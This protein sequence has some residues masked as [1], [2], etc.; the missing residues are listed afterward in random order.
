M[1]HNRIVFSTVIRYEDPIMRDHRVHGV[2]LLPGV[3]FLDLLVRILVRKGFQA[4]QVCFRKLLFK[5]AIAT[6]ESF[7][8]RIRFTFT[9]QG[10][11]WKITTESRKER[12][13]QVLDPEWEENMEGELHLE[14]GYAPQRQDLSAFRERGRKADLDEAYAI[15]RDGNIVH[16]PFMKGLGTAHILDNGLLAD[17]YLSAEADKYSKH[18]YFHPAFLD[19]STLLPFLFAL[20][21]ARESGD[22]APYIPI[23]VDQF[24]FKSNFGSRVSVMLHLRKGALG[25]DI[26]T[27][28]LAFCDSDG[29]TLA[30]MTGLTAKR[31]RFS[32]LIEALEDDQQAGAPASSSAPAV[33]RAAAVSAEGELGDVIRGDLRAMVG[34]M[35]EVP[36][37]D[38]SMDEG[39]YD[40]GLD[41]TALL[42]LVQQLEAKLAEKLYP[43]LLFEYTN[44][45]DLAGYLE[46]TFGERYREAVGRGDVDTLESSGEQGV[47][48]LTMQ[49]FAAPLQA[50]SL[51]QGAILVMAP[52]QETFKS[53]AAALPKA[54]TVYAVLPGREF[55]QAGQQFTLN[56]AAL[57]DGEALLQALQQQGAKLRY[58]VHAWNWLQAC[59]DLEQLDAE[60]RNS[61]Y[62]LL[63][64]LRAF[65]NQHAGKPLRV[66]SLY[67]GD[68]PGQAPV[69]AAL[70]GFAGTVQ[71]ESPKINLNAV[72]LHGPDWQRVVEE[73]SD[74]RAGVRDVV[75][76]PAGR[77]IRV[78]QT[79]SAPAQAAVA[80]RQQGC[81]VITGG[82]GGLGRL[83][84]EW[85]VDQYAAR[86]VLC[87]RS[88][89]SQKT[90]ELVAELEKRGGKA[91]YVAVDIG[92]LAETK[93]LFQLAQER[94]GTVHGILHSAGVIRDAFLSN[95]TMADAEAVL[96][97]KVA[98]TLNL[99][100]AS[101]NVELDFFLTCSSVAG[102]L[103]N[104]GQSD[105]AY[106][107]AFMD[108]FALWREAQQVGGRCHGNTVSVNWPIWA[109]GGMQLD[110]QAVKA[111]AAGSGMVPLSKQEGLAFVAQVIGFPAG[112]YAIL[113]GDPARMQQTFV[114]PAPVAPQPSI[115]QQFAASVQ[116]LPPQVKATKAS[117]APVAMADDEIAVIGLAGRYPKAEDVDAFW[118]NLLNGRDC[119]SEVPENRWDHGPFFDPQKG[120]FGKTNGKWGGFLD[121]PEGFDPLFFNLNPREMQFADPQERLFLMAA[122]QAMED[123]GYTRETLKRMKTGVYCGVMWSD[124]YLIGMPEAL[125]G[126]GPSG[127]A[128][129][130]AIP[131]RVSFVLD[132]NGPSVAIDTMCSSVLTSLNF[133]CRSI[134]TGETDAAF[135]GGV[136]LSLHPN[137]YLQLALPGFLSSDGRC[138]AFGEGGDGY[139]PSEGVGVMLVKRLSQA[140]ADGDQIYGVIKSLAVNH[141]GKAGGFTVPS[142]VA[143]GNLIREALEQK[144][145][146]PASISY[147]ETHGT[148]TDLGDPIEI[149]G[150][151]RAFKS[152]DLSPGQIAIGSVKSNIGHLESAAAVAGLT[153]VLLQLKHGKLVPSLHSDVLNPQIRFDQVPFKVQHEAQDWNPTYDA[154]GQ[155]LPR[156]AALSSFGAG[157]TNGHVIIEEYVDAETAADD[158]APQ[159]LVLSAR[160][161]ERLRVYAGKL[162][163]HLER[164][165]AATGGLDGTELLQDVLQHAAQLLGMEADDLDAATALAEQGFDTVL[166]AQLAQQLAAS[167]GPLATVTAE[168]LTMQAP[169]SL[170]AGIVA[171]QSADVAVAAS[172]R[173]VAHTLQV[174]RES[175]EARL[176]FSATSLGQAAV[177]FSAFAAGDT[178]AG[179]LFHEQEETIKGAA[180]REL[181]QAVQKALA[182]GDRQ[183]LMALWV[184]GAAVDWA[185][186]AEARARRV[187]LPTY[188]FLLNPVWIPTL[189]AG[190]ALGKSVV[191]AGSAGGAAKLHPFLDR[192]CSTFYDL[193]FATSLDADAS[194]MREHVVQGQR[195]FPGV[196]YLEMA[197]AAGELAA[198]A[199]VRMLRDVFWMR[200]LVVEQGQR[201]VKIGLAPDQ[202]GAAFEVYEELDGKRH[203]FSKGQVLWD[204]DVA[205]AGRVDLAAIQAR[206]DLRTDGK[207]CYEHFAAMGFDY[208][209]SYQVTQQ[210]W[211]GDGE[212]LVE[213]AL[214]EPDD[215]SDFVLPPGLT[216]GALR[217]CVAIGFDDG[218][219]EGEAEP[220]LLIPFS[221]GEI[222]IHGRLPERVFAHAV[223]VSEKQQKDT[224]QY[225]VT[226]SDGD[227]NVLAVFKQFNARAY[228][229][230]QEATPKRQPLLA[231]EPEWP[232]IVKIVRVA[233]AVEMVM[234][235][236]RLLL[237]GDVPEDALAAL[238]EALGEGTDVCHLALAGAGVEAKH[239]VDGDELPNWFEEQIAASS[240]PDAILLW[241]NPAAMDFS[242]NQIDAVTADAEA[243]FTQLAKLVRALVM[244]ARDKPMRVVVA[245]QGEVEGGAPVC[246]AVISLASSLRPLHP[247]L[248]L[249][250]LALEP[251]ARLDQAKVIADELCDPS[252]KHGFALAYRDGQ[253][254]KRGLREVAPEPSL[255]AAFPE[256]GVCLIS[257]G[258]GGL[259]RVFASHLAE[260]YQAKLV[261]TGRSPEDPEKRAF[262]ESLCNAIYVQADVTTHAGAQLARDAAVE[263]FGTLDGV[264]HGAGALQPVTLMDATEADWQRVLQPKL[265]GTVCLDWV[266]RNDDLKVFMPLGSI[267]A[268]IGD[269]GLGSY[270]FGNCFVD[271]FCAMR[272]RLQDAGLRQGRAI[273][274]AW[275]LWA[276]G[277]ME[278]DDREA[279][280]YSYSGMVPMDSDLALAFFDQALS[281][282]QAHWVVAQ[283]QPRKVRQAFGLEVA[284]TDQDREASPEARQTVV[285]ADL[286]DLVVAI[287]DYLKGVMAKVMDIEIG[288]IK[289]KTSFDRYGID[290]IV[291]MEMN[292][293]MEEAF[294]G[295][296][297]TLFFEHE[298]LH[299]IAVFLAEEHGDL[300]AEK[301]EVSAPSST[302]VVEATQ[303]QHVVAEAEDMAKTRN[304]LSRDTQTQ[305]NLRA[306]GV[307]VMPR[308]QKIAIIGVSG[309]YP[310]ARNLDAFWELLRKGESAITEVPESRWRSELFYDAEAMAPGKTAL[311]YGGFIDGVA[312]FD[313]LHFNMSP[314]EAAYQDPQERLFLEAVWHA[315][316]NA[317][318]SRKLLTDLQKQAG[319][320]GVYVASQYR[321][322]PMLAGDESM[323]PRYS[324]NSASSLA[325]RVSYFFNLSG[326]SIAL[327]TA[328]SGSLTAVHLACE[329]LM[330][331]SSSMAIA[332]GVNLTLHP[333]KYIGLGELGLVGTTSESRSFGEGDGMI[334]GEGVGAL[335]LKPLEA[336]IAD[337]D[338]I[339]GVICASGVNHGGKTAGFAMPNPKMQAKL[340]NETLDRAG[341]DPSSI[342]YI[343]AA[344][345]G[346]PVSDP[347]EH[348][349]LSRA[350]AALN[351]AGRKVAVGS[352]KSNIGHLEAASG[353]SQVTKVL[354]QMQHQT[355]VPSINAAT[356]PPQI[357]WEKGPLQLQQETTA[358][359]APDGQPLRAAVSSFGAGGSNAHVILEAYQAEKPA[360]VDAELLVVFSARNQQR[361][362]A[363]LQGMVSFFE[364]QPDQRLCDVAFS[365]YVGREWQEERVA[366]VAKDVRD[367][368]E[369]IARF[370][371]GDRVLAG[372]YTSQEKGIGAF[373]ESLLEGSAGR[374]FME[375]LLKERDY[376]K[377]AQ[378][379]V[380][381][382]DLPSE[383]LFPASLQPRRVSLPLYPFERRHC[384]LGNTK[385]FAK[386]EARDFVYEAPE[387]EASA[388]LPVAAREGGITKQS[389]IEE[390]RSIVG[391]FLGL[392]PHELAPD[393]DLAD[394]GF[395]SFLGMKLVNGLNDHFDIK[396]STEVLY[397]YPTLQ[398]LAAYLVEVEQLGQ[399]EVVEEKTEKLPIIREYPLA[400]NQKALWFIHQ[401]E[402]T[403]NMPSAFYLSEDAEVPLLREALAFLFDRHDVLRATTFAKDGELINHINHF[404]DLPF[405]LEDCSHM[406]A[407]AF[408]EHVSAIG[409]KVFD[410]ESEPLIRAHVLVRS[411]QERVLLVVIHHI[412]FD[413]ASVALLMGE[414]AQAYDDLKA[415]KQ[416]KLPAL[417]A[418]YADYV[419]WQQEMLAGEEGEAHWAYWKKTL[420]GELPMLELP[421]DYPRK[422]YPTYAG[423]VVVAELDDAI[424]AGLKSLAKEERASL[425]VVM[426]A[427]FHTLLVRH[428]RQRDIII[429][430][431]LSGRS[432]SRFENVLG[433]FVNVVPLRAQVD[434]NPSFR[435]FLRQMKRVVIESFDHGDY[436]MPYLVKKLDIKQDTSRDPVAQVGFVLH[437]F[438]QR[439]GGDSEDRGILAGD[440]GGESY[441]SASQDLGE[442]SMEVVTMGGK[443]VVCIKFNT[444]LYARPRI[445]GMIQNYLTLL[446]SILAQP[447]QRV[448]QLPM[449]T[450]HEEQQIVREWNVYPDAYSGDD[451]IHGMVMA[452][453]AK[454]GSRQAVYCAD[455]KGNEATLNYDELERKSNQLAHALIEKGVQPETLVAVCMDRTPELL[456]VL[457]AILK[458]G[459][460]YVPL[461]PAYPQDRLEFIIKDT[462]APVLI[463]QKHL[464]EQFPQGTAE[465]VFV[466]DWNTLLAGKPETAPAVRVTPD[467]LAYVIFTSGSTGKPKGVLITHRNVV[468]L[469]EAT[470]EW[471]HFDEK[472][473]W[474]LFHS[475]AFDFSVWEIWGALCYG[476]KLVV[477]PH[478][479]ARS[480]EAVHR[481]VAEQKVTIF[482][483]TPS[484]FQQFIQVDL[485]Q[486]ARMQLA[487]REIVF[488]GEALDF[489]G[490]QHWFA[491][492]GYDQPR[493]VNMYGI[494]ETTVHVTYYP[495]TQKRVAEAGGSVI[496]VPIP[497]L[498]CYLL[499]ESFN[500]V[501]AGVPAEIH[502]GGAGLARG[503][504]NRPDL[505]A[506][507]FIPNAFSGVAGSR[508]YRSGD[509]ARF[510]PNGE[511]EYL[512]RID[513]QVKIRGFRIELGEIESVMTSYPG[514]NAAV[515]LVRED[516][517]GDKRLVGYLLAPELAEPAED[518]EG[519]VGPT[520][521]LKAFMATRLP[522]YMIPS[523][524][525]WLPEFPL[526][527][528][529]KTDR[530]KLPKPDVSRS[531]LAEDYVAPRNETEAALV[532]MW[533]QILAVER[534][535]IYDNFFELGGHSLL[536]TQVISAIRQHF[537]LDISPRVMFER[538]TIAAL[539]SALET[540]S[541]DVK[542]SLEPIEAAGRNRPLPLSF[543]Q[544]RLWFF[545]QMEPGNAS[546][547]LASAFRFKGNFKGDVFERALNRLI[548]RHESLRTT[549]L[550]T[551]EDP[552]QVI[553]EQLPI[554][555]SRTSLSHYPEADRHVALQQM[556]SEEAWQPFDLQNGPLV[557]VSLFEMD[558]DDQVLL[559][560]F[561]H[562]ISDGWS[563]GITIAELIAFYDAEEQQQ[564]VTL[565]EMPIQYADFAV[566]QREWWAERELQKQIDY[567]KRNLAGANF[568][569]DLP[570]DF[571]R[572]RT[573]SMEGELAR[574]HFD[575]ELSVQ[576]KEFCLAQGVT[577][578]MTLLSV[579]NVLLSRY[580]GQRD[581]LIG[582]AIAN[583]N[584]AELENLIGFFVNT[585]VLRTDLAGNPTCLDLLEQ[586][587]ENTLNAYAHQDVSFEKLVEELKPER[588]PSRSPIYQVAFAMQNTP[589]MDMGET[590]LEVEEVLFDRRIARWDLLFDVREIDGAFVGLVEYDAALFRDATIQRML[591]HYQTLLQAFISQPRKR[592]SNLKM[593]SDAERRVL[594]R[595]WND[596][597]RE[598]PVHLGVP[599]LFEAQV[600]RT[601][602]RT[603]LE[604]GKSKVSYEALNARANVVARTLQTRGAG[605][606]KRV[607]VFMDRSPDMIVAMLAIMKAGSA[608]VP[609]DPEYPADRL[610]YMMADA[611]LTAI[612]SKQKLAK[613]MPETDVPVVLIDGKN[614]SAQHDDT[615]LKTPLN[616][617]DV[618]Y[619]M[620]TSGSTGRPKGSEIPHRGIIRLVI[621]TNYID[622]KV[623]GRIAQVAS[624][625]FDAATFEIWGPLLNGGQVIGVP[626]DVTLETEPLAAYL[627]EHKV[628]GM[629]MTAGLFNQH[630]RNKPD[631][632]A[633]VKTLSVGGEA[634]DPVWIRTALQQG[635][636]GRILNGYGPTE[637]TTFASW[638]HVAEVGEQQTN[639]PIGYPIANTTLYVL[640]KYLQLQPQGV[641]GE[642]CIGG[643]GLGLSYFNRPDL[644]ADKFIPDPFSGKAGARLYRTGDLTRTLEDGAITYLGRIDTQVKMRGYRIELGEIEA[645]LR[646]HHS[647]KDV[648]VVAR[649]DA[650]GTL[651]LVGYIQ[652]EQGSGTQDSLATDLR[653]FL[654]SSLPD[655]M[656]PTYFVIMDAFPLTPN[657]KID[658]RALPDPQVEKKQ[659][660][661]SFKAPRTAAEKAL[662]EIWQELLQVER[663]G[664]EDN[665]F[666]LG[667]HS[668]LATRLTTQIRKR[669]R[670]DIPIRTFFEKATLE[671][672]ADE[673]VNRLM[674]NMTLPP[675]EQ[676][677]AEGP[678]PIPEI[679]RSSAIPLSFSQQ[680]LW[681]IDQL[682]P[683]NPAYNITGGVRIKGDIEANA[684]EKALNLLVQRHETLRTTFVAPDGE[685]YQV[686][687]ETL[688]IP[689]ERLDI[690]DVD[691][692]DR[693]KAL[694]RIATDE[695][696]TPFNLAIGPLLR[697]K[698]VHVGENDFAL[699]INMHHIVSDGWSLGVLI[700]ELWQIMG[701]LLMDQP[702][703][704]PP[705]PCQFADFVVWHRDVMDDGEMARQHEYWVNKL[706]GANDVLDIPTDY[707]RPNTPTFMGRGLSFEISPELTRK[708]FE[709]GRAEDATLFMVMMTGFSMLMARYSGQ[710]DLLIGTPSANRNRYETELMIGLFVNTLAIRSNYEARPTVREALHEMRLTALD[711]FAHNE[712]PFDKLVEEFVTDRDLSRNPLVQV[713]LSY[714]NMPMPVMSGEDLVVEDLDF[715][716][717]ITRNEMI[718]HLTE[719]EQ[720][721]LTGNLIYSLDL[722]S[723]ASMK[724]LIQ[725][726]VH[727]LEAMVANPDHDAL[728]LQFMGEDEVQ[729]VVYE[730]NHTKASY[731]KG[732]TVLD[733]Y[734]A[735][736]AKRADQLA[737]ADER[738]RM[739]YSHLNAKANQLAHK[740]RE[741]GVG[742]DVLV[743]I[744]ME[745]RL[746]VIVALLAI[747][748]AGGAYVPMDSKHPKDRL[749]MIAEDSGMPVLL[750]HR[751]LE[752]NLPDDV[753]PVLYLDDAA[754]QNAK[755]L[756]QEL[757]S[758]PTTK[759]DVPGFCNRHLA[760]AIYTSGSTGLP[761][762]VMIEHAQLLNYTLGAMRRLQIPEG[763]SF[764]LVSTFAADLGNTSIYGSL[765]LGGSLHVL[766]TETATLG[767]NLGAY[768]KQNEIEVIKIVPS[769]LRALLNSES[770]QDILPK[771]YLV[772]GGEACTAELVREVQA[773]E[774]S[775]RLFN[776]YGPSEATVG[777]TAFAID[778]APGEGESVLPLGRPFG[779]IQLYI[780]D[781]K[782]RPVPV[783]FPGELCIAGD[784]VARG[785]M[786]R[787]HLTAERFVPNPFSDA[788]GSRMYRTGDLVRYL[789]DGNVMF[790]GRIDHQVKIRGYR[791]ELG[792]IEAEISAMDA[793]DGCVVMAK[794]HQGENRIVAWLGAGETAEDVK[795]KQELL[796]QVRE[797]LAERLPEYMMPSAFMVLAAIPLTPNGKIDRKA[798][799]EPEYG[800]MVD[801][802][803]YQE[804]RNDIER[805]IVGTYQHLLGLDRVGVHDN[806]FR[807]GGHSL[808][809]ARLLAHLRK[810]FG[811]E[812]SPRTMFE[813][814]TPAELAEVIEVAQ[815]MS[816]TGSQAEPVTPEP[817][818][819]APAA[820]DQVTPNFGAE[821]QTTPDEAFEEGSLD[822]EAFE[823][824]SLDDEEAFEEGSLDDE[825][826]EEGSLD[827][828]EFE[829]GSL[830]DE[831][832]E[833][834]TLDDEDKN[835]NS[836]SKPEPQDEYEEGEL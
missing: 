692:E 544:Q 755:G 555:L 818:T 260:N 50:S 279:A 76:S 567:W 378:L 371:A 639:I 372:C 191:A 460:A 679:D 294:E 47:L 123:A 570:T 216:D 632:F 207:A 500:L 189:E 199:P 581:I 743:G 508:L 351:K 225:D 263:H 243:Y 33:P 190:A 623:E 251:A 320:V 594:V 336:A 22:D 488:G 530:R 287:E 232:P 750:S 676:Q 65:V 830:D 365:L 329:S 180:L 648:L 586:V 300:M 373:L 605:R 745:S 655:Y 432:Q 821:A 810:T 30:E 427:A 768:V 19:C 112:N 341:I 633:S 227:G 152:D 32:G 354:L 637:S 10:E 691:P 529:G 48:H 709:L 111:M 774:V 217:S 267:S 742:P 159:V 364:E 399:A 657:G 160:S 155:A 179:A 54:N 264:I 449:L 327:D 174:G 198:E 185:S 95:K 767:E 5:R 215:G 770:P 110:P 188:P 136:N 288:Q 729:R 803:D 220:Q 317:G 698:F 547:N 127:R 325:N 208:G 732:Q 249:F 241:A 483:Q 485:A 558:E 735:Q 562:I 356:S 701:D 1:K 583:R 417:K 147:I 795:A 23:Y 726:F 36:A 122:W 669:F 807:L 31:I 164:L 492:R 421:T 70:N 247:K 94:F 42:G 642:L 409:L 34:A 832:F 66:V 751:A 221:V 823:E 135:V 757:A 764:A 412:I 597:T 582:S 120:V 728:D 717:G 315:F 324:V 258:M 734:E 302:T 49:D 326:P 295:V 89:P 107:N 812:V 497:D 682:E 604:F 425:F 453:A 672:L 822:D 510:L 495:L 197:R 63:S 196:G 342:S 493:L 532:E 674:N 475:F 350:F 458:A 115:E 93:A 192:N 218:S 618:A 99:H 291:I 57:A 177:L 154:N 523:A 685:P 662:A 474:T 224:M 613:Q 656:I 212:A 6:G 113:E 704:L 469:F 625:V 463:G 414:L 499:D 4:E 649:K 269:F 777:V 491:A 337:G 29:N 619:V 144:H 545:D 420:D 204:L 447:E 328:C 652:T 132:L 318:Y 737:L 245:Y 333:Y 226:L 760:Y 343:E 424:V 323:A 131:N 765:V 590:G 335:I 238:Q 384:W 334:P 723:E 498:Q 459:G 535:G 146:D 366:F 556:I 369:K 391:E 713:M 773:L 143:Q 465:L 382:T 74:E 416:P 292:R 250:T 741:L 255:D 610:E 626:K 569:L 105:Y 631:T 696:R 481:L 650:A 710:E 486:D 59:A 392:A 398:E 820:Q 825:T 422:P 629:F 40:L 37:D 310:G 716:A 681:F 790:M 80:L 8:R 568:Q 370:L 96:S 314:N 171:A 261:L 423:D 699:L 663:V 571:P 396:L 129:F 540:G 169:E 480:P 117:A 234:A 435:D 554:K 106:A 149:A 526:T 284:A 515:V 507:R 779:N 82:A 285:A 817:V 519:F 548:A 388:T 736:A 223:V 769:H 580:S 187:S 512:G 440:F 776:H 522:E 472:D 517:P 355:L 534:V 125:A 305:A 330:S 502:V 290:S 252:K 827:D 205:P 518:E 451:T 358:W 752:G 153:K 746:E 116:D 20:D 434:D 808:M 426:L 622:F 446:Q 804:P 379:W 286:A 615:D 754:E 38:V 172:L 231:F 256:Q 175:F 614:L 92:D 644:T 139:V 282:S 513:F 280:M 653:G 789:P 413:G 620:Y 272:N 560:V 448:L 524:L 684:I 541:D 714:Q 819:E 527:T 730:W 462:Q 386:M 536:A 467:H 531:D 265:Q 26:N 551:E 259:G 273:N 781:Q 550:S 602:E 766:G 647:V 184:K 368:R 617:S 201:E 408:Q 748:K 758:L 62:A 3:T 119:I 811:V 168:S 553:H 831:G 587:Q 301:L 178:P 636:P 389:L 173:D 61:F 473:V 307:S 352:V 800:E 2:R 84:A 97:A 708:L 784:S 468:R 700:R 56:P 659:D 634:L 640:D 792:E 677:A 771:R 345:T 357:N 202:A 537:S 660:P 561:H 466:E 724:R 332:G 627:R 340:I 140:I 574:F 762:G 431:L 349:G 801:S 759:P 244:T 194:F 319:G 436:P 454:F 833:E 584:R 687:A 128:L 60:L 161:E 411:P 138:R 727:L 478:L 242:Q 88:Q 834:G 690:S 253:R 401:M 585:L 430:T 450:A 126:E 828:E 479:V 316:E 721:G 360:A 763:L 383:M 706:A 206:C 283:G 484:A 592:V 675:E 505:T 52:D 739:T 761:K 503:Y 193:A 528:N 668:L 45:E 573:Q 539:A 680:R 304:F 101:H 347:I 715:E 165:A 452:N 753:V 802:G 214:A 222:Q 538:P 322:Y 437:S 203:V 75:Y 697:A 638:F 778:K 438:A 114:A 377:L 428:T 788:P 7:D 81:Y 406:S 621:N 521:E 501:P 509:L 28:D 262:L 91:F 572:P 331:G 654:Q 346:S 77:R 183:Q 298:N 58:V 673:I 579:L 645:N 678:E 543:A 17:L 686:I 12:D 693:D 158:G 805:E 181:K 162:A 240:F 78:V 293:H 145:I 312:E 786:K 361:L 200:P 603:A 731:P 213:L 490:L 487:L 419:L 297:N 809:A 772:M 21:Q 598:C 694:Q 557:R 683:N 738:G 442:L 643:D 415:R 665:F 151:T 814:P 380:S 596:T 109:D 405:F 826:F 148:G 402:P 664:L 798:L 797:L 270:G 641:P 393:R 157:G 24:R 141:G 289:A 711:A 104:A 667:G 702:S 276:H 829:E 150:L 43:T 718:V 712:Y 457:L 303:A 496:G 387:A 703:S 311:K 186:L 142:P 670:V 559:M 257:G 601:P 167:G 130:S 443:N 785:Y 566:W 455:E 494:T 476:G 600:K 98:G 277:A 348:A 429:G 791:I 456:V 658:R 482:N 103:G 51:E 16:G 628:D 313:P 783:G 616:G 121:N 133:A 836:G 15:A 489:N 630:I 591:G 589:G 182:A 299:D 688:A 176:A 367:L 607:G 740:L 41:S 321:H 124:Y 815:F 254:L 565:P 35:M 248:E 477:V 666:E 747:L 470:E 381:G 239:V 86:V 719:N 661:D 403:N 400:E 606:G 609:L 722:F 9:P 219:G 433:Y 394:Y 73:L 308:R 504:L 100:R 646:Q 237:F 552:V 546:Y 599:E 25:S 353:I 525:V 775:E 749:A 233:H 705:L 281:A 27:C 793:I 813:K 542:Q 575:K 608:Y 87:G 444:D 563:V 799:P 624:M 733:A 210:A 11:S 439:Q 296:P 390:L 55:S 418:R 344:A 14:S 229:G 720:D 85:L 338:N 39:F 464:Q 577:P 816:G 102:L 275:P 511:M 46:E 404:N 79:F 278:M 395:D 787:P 397:D 695:A 671:A 83:F 461:D 651:Q 137:K 835:R 309:R 339:Q 520:Q 410:I 806:F 72:G 564:P 306:S 359:Q 471:F 44:I 71:A 375:A 236:K 576:I 707:Q 90:D 514:V 156:R 374:A 796:E 67:R 549:F 68:S 756:W 195:L 69:V 230:K 376:D 824:G 612:V 209:R 246:E 744:C 228:Q 385:D 235:I 611:K 593:L 533:E 595:D 211:T 578:F 268:E 782:Q 689:L 266:T 118:Q 516:V 441:L 588:D 170:I 274:I 445:E 13:G 506:A 53:I 407:E 134:L 163:Q 363:L 64:L 108:R 18:F 780:L 794:Q 166:A 271:R 725:H 635:A 362:E